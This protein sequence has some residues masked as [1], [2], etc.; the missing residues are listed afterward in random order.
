M[1]DRR[2]DLILALRDLGAGLDLPAAGDPAAAAVARIRADAVARAGTTA[3]PARPDDLARRGG[4]RVA[5]VALALASVLA[6]MV[7]ALPGPRAA[8]ARLLGIGGVEITT[9]ATLDPG[10]SSTFDLGRPVPGEAAVFTFP[11]AADE[12]VDEVGPPAQAYVGRPEGGISL[13]WPASDRLPAIGDSGAGLLLT[14]FP[15]SGTPEI[16]K[17][18]GMEGAITSVTV[19]GREGAWVEGPHEMA[20]TTPDGD[21]TSARIAGNTLVWTDGHTT[22][23]LESELDRETAIDLAARLM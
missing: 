1:A 20:F 13:V 19:A 6:L 23:R 3:A 9:G 2:A 4:R 11:G 22:Y 8:L 5:V 16:R 10:L 14:A 7:T 15:T 18:V 21:A 12:L 17:R